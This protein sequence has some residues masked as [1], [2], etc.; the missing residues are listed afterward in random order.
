M[1]TQDAQHFLLTSNSFGEIVRTARTDLNLTQRELAARC[2]GI[3]AEYIS[4][5]EVGQKIP[6]IT[7]VVLLAEVLEL[8]PQRM[9]LLA[10][11]RKTPEAIKAVLLS[12]AV[13]QADAEW[14]EF[15]QIYL[16]VIRELP[17][18]KKRK[19]LKV[20]EVLA[21]GEQA[22]TRPTKTPKRPPTA[23]NE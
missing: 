9:L 15:K 19:V 4:Q 10:Y 2:G 23:V 13:E 7:L 8:D 3:S 22:E 17:T 14:E 5:I 1:L 18:T 16:K 6:D 12:P 20:L 21:K 11:W